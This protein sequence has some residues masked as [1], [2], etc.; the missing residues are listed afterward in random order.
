[1][2]RSIILLK[3]VFEYCER[4][5][6]LIFFHTDIVFPIL[7]V[8]MTFLSPLK[9]F[10]AFVKINWPYNC[11]STSVLSILFWGRVVYG[12]SLSLQ[13]VVLEFFPQSLPQSSPCH[14]EIPTSSLTQPS[15][16]FDF[17]CETPAGER[18]Q[19]EETG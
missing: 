15:L 19:G 2:F 4:H 10:D 11:A 3:L 16:C 9:Y 12:H 17:K 7:F 13:D 1:M 5:L 6:K 18:S 14:T 8:E